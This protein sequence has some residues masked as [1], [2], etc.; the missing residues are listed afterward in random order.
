M[1]LTSCVFRNALP[2]A[3]AQLVV[4]CCA[5]GAEQLHDQLAATLGSGGV[6]VRLEN[7]AQFAATSSDAWNILAPSAAD[8]AEFEMVGQRISLAFPLGH[9]KSTL[10]ND[11]AFT[12]AFSASPKW[13]AVRDDC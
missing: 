3:S 12:A 10:S 7:E 2:I 1:F 5:E 6:E 11:D 13:L 9:I 4:S 8:V